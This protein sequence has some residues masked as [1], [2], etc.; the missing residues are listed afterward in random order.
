[1][2][3]ENVRV[4]RLQDL[5]SVSRFYCFLRYP[6]ILGSDAD[7]DWL[8]NATGMTS[9]SFPAPDTGEICGRII[10]DAG[11]VLTAIRPVS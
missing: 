7:P 1:M 8:A 9:Q 11:D 10:V 5:A 3:R 2:D 6:Q 4:Y